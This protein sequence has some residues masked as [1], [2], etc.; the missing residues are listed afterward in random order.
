MKF[1]LESK[2]KGAVTIGKEGSG[3]FCFCVII[4]GQKTHVS[5]KKDS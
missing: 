1:V 2:F 3:F 5:Y 4:K